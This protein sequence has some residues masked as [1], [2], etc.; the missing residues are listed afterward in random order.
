MS[1][2]RDY[3]PK[4]YAFLHSLHG[5]FESMNAS[6]KPHDHDSNL[7][8]YFASFNSI[9]TLNQDTL[10]ERFYLP[11]VSLLSNG[12]LR[13]AKKMGVSRQKIPGCPI[14]LRRLVYPGASSHIL[15]CMARL[16]GATRKIFRCILPAA[17]NR[18]SSRNSL[19][20]N[21]AMM[22]LRNN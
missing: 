8:R 2:P 19:R 1:N 3:G 5:I 17:T 13:G 6:F 15:N 22:S 7:W 12:T 20:L 4:L 11:Q 14:H 18:G 16:T 9:F 10:L 21:G